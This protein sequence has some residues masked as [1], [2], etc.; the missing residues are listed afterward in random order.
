M[1]SP[2]GA[3]ASA[4]L[5]A[6]TW[7]AAPY[8]AASR[9]RRPAAQGGGGGG[10]GGGLSTPVCFRPAAFVHRLA[11]AGPPPPEEGEA[12]GAYLFRALLAA[13]GVGMHKARWR[14]RILVLSDS[15]R[16]PPRARARA[17]GGHRAR[18]PRMRVPHGRSWTLAAARVTVP[19]GRWGLKR[20][21]GEAYQE[22]AAGPNL[23]PF[24][25]GVLTRLGP[26]AQLTGIRRTD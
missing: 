15:G 4:R 3:A 5:L 22:T 24:P 26:A 6:H 25:T 14:P 12:A 9:R 23:P 20:S 2:A 19:H 21:G 11:E 10:G 7:A 8:V 13:A 16:V 18:G 17:R 1:L